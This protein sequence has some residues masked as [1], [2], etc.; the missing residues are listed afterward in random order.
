MCSKKV[1]VPYVYLVARIILKGCQRN[2]EFF[3]QVVSGSSMPYTAE[4]SES[5]NWQIATL[6]FMSIYL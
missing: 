6:G 5:D 4:L 3:G 1:R 2:K